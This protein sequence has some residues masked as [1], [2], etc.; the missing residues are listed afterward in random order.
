M[1]T[2]PR[3]AFDQYTPTPEDWGEYEE[4]LDEEE[5]S[6]KLIWDGHGLSQPF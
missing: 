5:L 4:W 1:R 2:D 3:E 6:G